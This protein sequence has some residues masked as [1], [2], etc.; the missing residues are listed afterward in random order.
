MYNT[1]GLLQTYTPKNVFLDA[2]RAAM[3]AQDI[4]ETSWNANKKRY[5]TSYLDSAKIAAAKFDLSAGWATLIY[6]YNLKYW[7]D[8]QRYALSV[9]AESDLFYKGQKVTVLRSDG[10]S[11]SGR[12][13]EI[14][15]SH[16][17]FNEFPYLLVKNTETEEIIKEKPHVVFEHKEEQEESKTEQLTLL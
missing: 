3:Y 12:I 6:E 7:S 2:M 16:G 10:K 9:L 4:R 14:V 13:I 5:E 11:Y 1:L 15:P 17:N 8:I